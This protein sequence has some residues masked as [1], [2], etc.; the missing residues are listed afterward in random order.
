MN[1]DREKLAIAN[2]LLHDGKLRD[3]FD[4]VT[5]ILNT[6]RQNTDA[7]HI[8]SNIHLRAGRPD[9]ATSCAKLASDLAPNRPELLIQL[10]TCLGA[11]SRINDA[12][13]VAK[14]T[15]RLEIQAP[16]MLSNLGSLFSMC[17]DHRRAAD[18]FQ[19]AV[20]ADAGSAEYWYNLASAQRMLGFLDDAENSCNTAIALNPQDGQAFY[21]RSDLRIQLAENNHIAALNTLIADSDEAIRRIYCQ[22]NETS[23]LSL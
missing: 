14:N 7:W 2:Q 6:E 15:A 9:K 10:G 3:A 5:E 12:L 1:N 16:A 11:S 20:D 13:E 21:L 19:Q 4:A 22:C 18:C 8:L 17:N 23:H